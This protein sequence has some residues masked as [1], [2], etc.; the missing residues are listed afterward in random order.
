M[1]TKAHETKDKIETVAAAA[2]TIPMEEEENKPPDDTGEI[3]G[4]SNTN[5]TTV[6]EKEEAENLATAVATT[7]SMAIP[8]YTEEMYE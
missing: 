7:I 3:Y 2:T 4:K 6:D 1:T 8:D 5:N